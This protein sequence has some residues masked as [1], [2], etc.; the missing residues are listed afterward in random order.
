MKRSYIRISCRKRNKKR[1]TR[2]TQFLLKSLKK[3]KVPEKK[4][5]IN[6]HNNNNH[7]NK[8]RNPKHLIVVLEY[9]P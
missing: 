1:K 2:N 8:N 3:V 4:I 7:H 5:I 6:N 9:L